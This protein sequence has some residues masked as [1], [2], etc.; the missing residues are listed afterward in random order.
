VEHSGI[1]TGSHTW[2]SISAGVQMNVALSHLII[3]SIRAHISRGANLS[4][5]VLSA[6]I[7]EEKMIE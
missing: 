1:R 4:D 7:F 2:Q 5:F 6:Q 3:C